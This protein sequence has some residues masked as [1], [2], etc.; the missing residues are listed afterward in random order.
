MDGVDGVRHTPIPVTHSGLQLFDA[1]RVLTPFDRG[2]T[3]EVF[4]KTILNGSTLEFDVSGERNIY[5][6][7]RNIY[8]HLKL[9][10]LSWNNTTSVFEEITDVTTDTACVVNNILHSAFS[11]V[12]AS[13]QGVQ[14]SSSNNLY[15]HKAFIETELS[16]PTECKNTWLV[17]QGYQ[18]E[19]QPGTAATPALVTRRAKN[20]TGN[21]NT[22]YGRLALDFLNVEKY[23]IP[24]VNLR[25]K[26][27]RA[28][29]EFAVVVLA[30][31]AGTNR[32]QIRIDEA[33]LFVHKVEV[34]GEEY[35]RLERSLSARPAFYEFL[36]VIPKTYLIPAGHNQMIE[37]DIFN[38]A[39]IRRLVVAM[40]L[41]EDF[42]GSLGSNPF[43]YRKFDLKRVMLY[44][45]G[46]SV[47][48]TPLRLD[49]NTR[50]YYNTIKALNAAHAGNGLKLEDFDNHFILVFVLTAD[51]ESSDDTTRPELTGGRL[52][53]HL[54]FGTALT[55]TVQVLLLGERK[56][57][58]YIDKNRSVLKNALFAT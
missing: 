54:E 26:M 23:L 7:L 29:S 55:D 22:F 56:S 57:A 39:P 17:T 9:K 53:L 35:A 31:L 25:I 15:G 4:S 38:A 48:C 46:A 43:H 19:K 11:N 51:L 20:L 50:A 30:G 34:A 45:E 36:E 37:E 32:Y 41:S 40:N 6:D 5:V 47:G 27:V 14:I 33:N 52:R 24:G 2:Y 16:H 49:Q 8:L 12:E 21:W 28:P 44:R 10:L 1:P 58:V 42:R 18:Y 13:L 3:E